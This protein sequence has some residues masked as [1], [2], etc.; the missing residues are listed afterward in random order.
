MSNRLRPNQNILTHQFPTVAPN[1]EAHAVEDPWKKLAQFTQARIGQGRSGSSLPTSAQLKFNLDH[2]MAR[3]AVNI[4]ADMS[5]LSHEMRAVNIDSYCLHSR[6]SDRTEYLQRPDLGRRLNQASVDTLIELASKQDAPRDVALILVDGLSSV[7]V[8][9]QGVAMCEMLTTYFE[10]NDLIST[11]LFLV[12]QGRVAIG[13]EIGELINAKCVVLIVGERPGLSSPDSLGIYYTYQPKL[14]LNDAYRNC[15]SN[16]R[17]QGLSI[18][19]AC[20]KTLWLIKESNK[21]KL[22]GVNLKDQQDDSGTV[23]AHSTDDSCENYNF[24][25]NKK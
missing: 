17:P 16:I 8:Q 25:L 22:S 12:E 1:N 11:P 24:L 20:H 6:A 13:D 7:G 18:E 10:N 4:P 9:Q 5:K 21:L 2:A 19:Q 15:I 14:G 3:D 23:L